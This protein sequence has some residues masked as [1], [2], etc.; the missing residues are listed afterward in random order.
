MRVKTSVKSGRIATNHNETQA[1]GMKVRS[2]V[3]SGRIA[4]NHNEMLVRSAA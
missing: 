4:T 2:S 3:K 1:R